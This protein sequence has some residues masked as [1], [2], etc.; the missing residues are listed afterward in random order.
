[1]DSDDTAPG[2]LRDTANPAPRDATR[3][4]P[5][6]EAGGLDDRAG[7]V[8]VPADP[9]D[10]PGD[11]HHRRAVEVRFGDTDAMGHVNNAVFLSYLEMARAGYY[12]RVTG[13]LFGIGATSGE[14]S[15]IL[16]DVRLTF[17]SPAWFAEILTLETR[18]SRIGRT[19][20]GMEHRITAPD[21][22]FGP[23]RLVATADTV[24]VMYAYDEG[25]VRPVP[26]DLAE[27]I[28]AFEGRSLRG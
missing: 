8:E 11:F 17:R 19:S 10:L 25:A 27:R 28:E 3:I 9:R 21:S 4:L 7:R 22:A 18:V 14:R 13:G 1:M 2:A 23:A 26:K 5:F 20:F 6:V 24:L 16:A 12:Q 15:F